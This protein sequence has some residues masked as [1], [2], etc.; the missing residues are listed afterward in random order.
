MS[1]VKKVFSIVGRLTGRETY[2]LAYDGVDLKDLHI[3]HEMPAGNSERIELGVFFST[4]SPQQD[5]LRVLMGRLFVD[6]S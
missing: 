4:P 1:L 5:I 2:S 6:Q 3:L